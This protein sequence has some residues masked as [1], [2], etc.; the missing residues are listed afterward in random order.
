MVA[1]A[2]GTFYFRRL[3]SLSV[4]AFVDLLGEVRVS[5]LSESSRQVGGSKHRCGLNL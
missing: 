2:L 5:L 1:S 4:G 3:L